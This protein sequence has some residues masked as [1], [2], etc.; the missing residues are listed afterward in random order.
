[1]IF[2]LSNPTELAECT[3][4]EAYRWSRG[5]AIYAAG[6]Q[7]PP[8]HLNGEVF[9]PGQANNFYIY[10][11]VGLA[12]YATRAKRFT[13]EMF[14]E[15]AKATAEQVTDDQLAKGMLF[16]PQS[17]ILETEVRTAERIATLIFDRNQAGVDRPGDIGTWLRD[18]LYQPEYRE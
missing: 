5:K 12:V 11:A 7:F 1:M 2:A 4:E 18:M 3:P 10:P 8:V 17:K 16:P 6:V 15:A 13:D 9:L 14:I